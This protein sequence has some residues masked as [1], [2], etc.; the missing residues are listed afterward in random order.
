MQVINKESYL[1]ANVRSEQEIVQIAVPRILN[2]LQKTYLVGFKAIYDSIPQEIQNFERIEAFKRIPFFEIVKKVAANPLALDPNVILKIEKAIIQVKLV[3]KK[4]LENVTKEIN[5]DEW[6]HLL[7]IVNFLETDST[8]LGIDLTPFKENQGKL[9]TIFLMSHIYPETKNI[10]DLSDT[11]FEIEQNVN[12]ILNQC[13]P[14]TSTLT[15]FEKK[16]KY[17][18]AY[19]ILQNSIKENNGILLPSLKDSFCQL[20]YRYAKD[21]CY[22]QM[23]SSTDEESGF[24]ASGNLMEISLQEQLSSIG[25]MTPVKNYAR[26]LEEMIFNSSSVFYDELNKIKPS[27]LLEKL[28]NDTSKREALADAL[29]LLSYSHQN[30]EAKNEIVHQELLHS[31]TTS[32]CDGKTQAL[33]SKQADFM[34]NRCGFMAS[35]RRPNDNAYKISSYDNV[36]NFYKVLF[37]E[38]SLEYLGKLSQIKNMQGL[39]CNR[40]S[41]TTLKE[42]SYDY[43]KSAFEIRQN[44][45]LPNDEK[46]KWDHQFLL[47][48]IR[49]SLIGALIV[50]ENKSEED[51]KAILSHIS[52]LEEFIKTSQNKGINHSYF[53]K[54]YL[55]IILKAK[56]AL[57]STLC[58]F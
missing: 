51:S 24:K 48:N 36:L 27:T 57:N 23:L 12:I 18:E 32:I 25:L 42:K 55:P 17:E 41:E 45:P 30:I 9:G 56:E 16:E 35:L 7:K 6:K 26:T 52:A 3:S 46:G 29:I 19:K 22:A 47:N 21:I 53:E 49:T 50:K 8:Y 38:N 10:F 13:D 4:L 5:K 2:S 11:P 39:I 31:F 14:K 40:S 28:G 37:G 20:V 33:M 54:S 1:Y 34:Y 58:I 43:F 15:N 44:M